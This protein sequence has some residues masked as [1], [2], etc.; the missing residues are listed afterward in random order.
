MRYC[1]VEGDLDLV[2]KGE[3]PPDDKS[4]QP[5][6]LYQQRP[7]RNNKI[8][9]GHWAALQG[10]TNTGNTFALDTGCVWGGQLTAMR[11][12]DE[13]IFQCDCKA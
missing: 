10:I 13:N 9:F 11:L 12:E 3:N 1:T 7:T 6:F 5:W 2:T 8:I 4:L